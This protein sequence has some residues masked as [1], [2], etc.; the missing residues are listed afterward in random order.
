LRIEQFDALAADGGRI[1]GVDLP[2]Q[3]ARHANVSHQ[4]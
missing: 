1:M 3:D 4:R 2:V